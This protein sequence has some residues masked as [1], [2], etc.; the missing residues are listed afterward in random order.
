[1]ADRRA[2]R[3][4]HVGDVGGGRTPRSRNSDGQWRRKR[5][6]A[7]SPR[8]PSEPNG[9]VLLLGLAA[10]GVVVVRILKSLRG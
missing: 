10:A 2:G 3:V 9:G 7:G 5:A 1:M 6:D 4:P 8:Q